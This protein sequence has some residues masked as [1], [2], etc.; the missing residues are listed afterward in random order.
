M[1]ENK[2]YYGLRWTGEKIQR[3]SV[4]ERKEW[5]RD[6]EYYELRETGNR[7]M[8][9]EEQMGEKRVYDLKKV[10]ENKEEQATVKRILYFELGG[11]G[12]RILWVLWFEREKKGEREQRVL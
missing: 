1:R 6:K 12:E 11:T 8:N 4:F 10:K 3:L 5:E 2:K 9:W 7:I